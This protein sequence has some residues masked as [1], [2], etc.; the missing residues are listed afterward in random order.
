MALVV[1]T[2]SGDNAEANSYASL[3][4]IRAYNAQRGNSIP[5][6]DEA[7]EA[8]AIKAMDYIESL[9]AELTGW[10]TYGILQPLAFPREGVVRHGDYMNNLF[11]PQEIKNAQAELVF[12]LGLGVI[13]LPNTEVG[14]RLKRRRVGPIE[15]E[16]FK[17]GNDTPVLRTVD[18]WLKPFISNPGMLLRTVRV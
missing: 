8:L 4:E 18:V 9:D 2:G 17:D 6:T 15:R 12:Q 1:E 5:A 13:P 10:R 3:E 11:V 14:Q 16:W 7:L